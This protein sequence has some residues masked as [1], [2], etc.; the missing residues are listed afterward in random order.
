MRLRHAWTGRAG[1]TGRLSSS[2][3]WHRGGQSP[4]QDGASK[5]CRRAAAGTRHCHLTSITTL[6][7]PYCST[8][9]YRGAPA[10]TRPPGR[11]GC[12]HGAKRAATRG[13]I[14]GG[15]SRLPPGRRGLA[16]GPAGT[17]TP[18][19]CPLRR[20]GPA[21]PRSGPAPPAAGN[22]SSPHRALPPGCLGRS[23]KAAAAAPP[24]APGASRGEGGA[25]GRAGGRKCGAG[26]GGSLA[27]S[28]AARAG[29]DF[30][31]RRGAGLRRAGGRL[32]ATAHR[33][34]RTAAPCYR[35]DRDRRRWRV[36]CGKPK[37]ESQNRSEVR[38]GRA[39]LTR[40]RVVFATRTLNGWRTCLFHC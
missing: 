16:G 36:I 13:P 7:V 34:W 15:L 33:G 3:S 19:T 17:A 24:A 30:T 26:R 31:Q 5:L 25:G 37:A 10:H 12:G 6:S 22:P 23:R 35:S 39:V 14:R 38:L 40:L 8:R 21:K 9:S 18:S 20:H 32:R 11:R 27:G 28:G 4:P 29:T 2:P 1:L